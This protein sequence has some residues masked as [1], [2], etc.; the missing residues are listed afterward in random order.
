ME[1][2]AGVE[3][4]EPPRGGSRRS[5]TIRYA[6]EVKLKAVRLVLEQGYS[7]NL[8]SREVGVCKTSLERWIGQYQAQGEAGLWSPPS[9]LAGQDR[10][11]AAVTEKIVQLKQQHPDFGVKRIAQFLRRMFLLPASA[12][13]V[14]ARLH[15]EGLMPPTAQ[16]RRRNLTRP[17]FFERA[18]PNQMWQSDI[19]TFRL[20]GRYAYLIGFLDD[21]SRFV[22]G[23]DLFRSPTAAAVIEVY[24]VAI[25]EYQPPKEMLTDNGRQYTTW[26]GTSRFEAELQKDRVSH[27][28]SRPHHPMTLGKIERFWESIW[29]EFLA[30]A[31]FESFDS[32]R[33]RIQLWIQYYN[34]RRPHQGI[35]G[36]CPA[37]RFFE[38]QSQLKKTLEAGLQD[39]LLELALRGQPRPPF[40]MVGR[41]DGQSVELRAEKGQLKL[42]VTNPENQTQELVYDLHPQDSQSGQGV[43]PDAASSTSTQ[44]PGQ[45]DGQSPSGAGGLDRPLQTGGGLPPTPGQLDHLQPLADPGDGGTAPSLGEPGQ[46]GPGGSLEPAA[47]GLAAET[48]T[49]LQRQPTPG[50]A[51]AGAEGCSQIRGEQDGVDEIP[52]LSSPMGDPHSAGTGGTVDRH[53][54]GPA[55]AGFAQNLLSVGT[56]GAAGPVAGV[57]AGPTGT[58]S[59]GS[60]TGGP[61]AAPE[62]PNPGAAVGHSPAGGPT[63]T[64]PGPAESSV[65]PS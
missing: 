3:R 56:S 34:Y 6:P 25:G 44:T 28:K 8:V 54:S 5:T 31:Q 46:P 32:A 63:A 19:F 18:T 21:Y 64:D 42:S 49:G 48:T 38:I 43:L 37:D 33:Q 17:R 12:E 7:R 57:A 39:N 23:A 36:L 22:V 61:T 52:Y 20:G 11:P 62:S 35:G 65:A 29:G 24:R 47:A 13:T 30:R 59:F 45:C 26:R 9:P 10:L 60:L 53:P 55:V 41:L 15:R 51:P 27:I 14:R 58:P 2:K 50:P 4:K 40:Y 16:P 1:A